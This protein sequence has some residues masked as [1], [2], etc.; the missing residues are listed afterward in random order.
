MDG[1]H[2]DIVSLIRASE[3]HAQTLASLAGLC[4]VLIVWQCNRY[5]DEIKDLRRLRSQ[6][7]GESAATGM[8]SPSLRY[9]LGFILYLLTFLQ[10]VMALV[11]YTRIT[12]LATP[13]SCQVASSTAT[14][15]YCCA[16][17]FFVP[18]SVLFYLSVVTFFFA[19]VVS[20]RTLPE[21]IGAFWF[22]MAV[23]GAVNIV[24]PIYFVALMSTVTSALPESE[25]IDLVCVGYY[26]AGGFPLSLIAYV[27]S[28]CKWVRYQST[29]YFAASCALVVSVA[30]CLS[31]FA[32]TQAK[33]G[34][35]NCIY[36]SSLA[37]AGVVFLYWWNIQDSLMNYKLVHQM[38]PFKLAIEEQETAQ[39]IEEHA[40]V[41][42]AAPSPPPT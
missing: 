1:V 4:A 32:T 16:V 42:P 21:T 39:S 6:Q 23:F 24:V 15:V 19:F 8:L 37:V 9:K 41:D 31:A 11:V 20:A 29:V 36:A 33:L 10:V 17:G 5:V 13:A 22:S 34:I 40:F 26:I 12:L 2:V 30:V 18:A 7:K 14:N 3:R 28:R 35:A 25:H 38:R 27:I